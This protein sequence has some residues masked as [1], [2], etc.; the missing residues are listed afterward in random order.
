MNQILQVKLKV[1][2]SPKP[3]KAVRSLTSGRSP[4]KALAETTQLLCTPAQAP[5]A[6]APRPVWSLFRVR[7]GRTNFSEK[8]DCKYRKISI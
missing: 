7:I 1:G 5:A 4:G 6:G 3:N 8:E 2:E